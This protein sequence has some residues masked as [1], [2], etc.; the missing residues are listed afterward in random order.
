MENFIVLEFTRNDQGRIG[1]TAY[2]KET[3][4]SADKKYY[5]I[6]TTAADS[7]SPVHGAAILNWDGF[8][9]DYKYYEHPTE[10]EQSGE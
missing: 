6:L 10:P 2:A 5:Q 3:R 9:L 7:N 8:E 4:N 1:V